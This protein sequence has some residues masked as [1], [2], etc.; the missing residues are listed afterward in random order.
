MNKWGM[1][2]Y[3]LASTNQILDQLPSTL[4]AKGSTDLR[5]IYGADFKKIQVIPNKPWPELYF[6]VL[7]NIKQTHEEDLLLSLY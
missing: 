7:W 6:N 4:C 2:L 5:R 1:H 3:A